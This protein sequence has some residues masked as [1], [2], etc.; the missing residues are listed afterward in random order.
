MKNDIGK[1]SN[2]NIITVLNKHRQM[3]SDG[4]RNK[5]LYEAIKKNITSQTSFLDI[6]AG[7]GI[8]AILAAKLGARRVV[9]VE[10]EDC[11]IP[12]INQQA[13]ENGV[14]DKIEIIHAHSDSLSIKGKFDLIVSEL[15][16]DDVFEDN[17]L[18]SFI[19]I[20]NRFLAPNGILIP[21][22][23]ALFAVPSQIEN[24]TLSIPEEL[25]LSCDFFKSIYLNFPQIIPF[26][27][28]Q[29]IKFLAA[30]KKL[31][32]IDFKKTDGPYNT[33]DLSASWSLENINES[34]A[35]ITFYRSYFTD[36]EILN[37]FESKSWGSTIYEY[38]PFEA[39]AGEI[40]F[41]LNM[42]LKKKNWSVSLQ[43]SKNIQKQIFSPVF[44]TGHIKMLQAK[45]IK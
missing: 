35:I 19:N 13:K 2:K 12:I 4:V 33:T 14:Y 30:P 40:R 44:A 17:T 3:L 34:N 28:R 31:T 27:E 37:N 42:E 23:I 10:I 8:W 39:S 18:E 1:T 43:S 11:L 16:G 36:S 32:E 15:F 45:N 5:L 29:N 21:Q 25:P 26:I 38:V 41:N 20:Q 24:S 22:K 7:T 9:A 6:G